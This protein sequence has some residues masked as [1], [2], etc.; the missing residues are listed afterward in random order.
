[1]FSHLVSI[2]VIYA[3]IVIPKIP[4]TSSRRCLPALIDKGEEIGAKEEHSDRTVP[5][6]ADVGEVSRT[7]DDNVI[8]ETNSCENDRSTIEKLNA[9][10]SSLSINWREQGM[11]I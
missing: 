5:S 4:V 2:H 1:M 9:L 8:K 10:K 3:K 7:E 6:I 11:I